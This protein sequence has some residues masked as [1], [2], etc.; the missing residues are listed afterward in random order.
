[1]A[2]V[3]LHPL[4]SI[5]NLP[6]DDPDYVSGNPLLGPNQWPD[7]PGFAKAVDDYYMAVFNLGRVLLR[8]FSMA[9]GEEPTF[10]TNT[11]PSRQAS[12]D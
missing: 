2:P 3:D 10:S 6:P 4:D 11:S 8:G 9:I 5:E 12:Y 7:L 1:M